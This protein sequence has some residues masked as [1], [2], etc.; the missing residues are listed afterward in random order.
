MV[1]ALTSPPLNTRLHHQSWTPTAMACRMTETSP[2]TPA[3]DVVD[4]HGCSIHQLVPCTG[5]AAA[6]AWNNHGQYIAA[7]AKAVESFLAAGRLNRDEAEGILEAAAESNC[8]RK[9]SHP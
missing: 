5:P 1:C 2:S 8:G 9:S 6:V 3:G 7:M 4:E